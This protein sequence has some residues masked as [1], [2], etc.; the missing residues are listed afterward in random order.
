MAVRCWNADFGEGLF[1][2]GRRTV[3]KAGLLEMYSSFYPLDGSD[4]NAPSS[5]TMTKGG[6]F[7]RE[8]TDKLEFVG[9]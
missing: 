3:E 5:V 8:Q 6:A 4:N 2:E 1:S 9:D 7:L